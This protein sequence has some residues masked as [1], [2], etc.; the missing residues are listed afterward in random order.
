MLNG[1]LNVYKERGYTSFDVVA[2][3][4]GITKQNKIGHTGTLDP[5]AEGVLPVCLGCAT[6]ISGMLDDKDKTYRAVMLLGKDTDTQDISGTL[7]KKGD[8][9]GVTELMVRECVSTF[10]GEIDQIPPMYSALK[11]NG[12]KLVDLARKGQTVERK[13]RHI[14]VFDINIEEIDL[15]RVTMSVRCSR[16]T[17]IRTLCHDIGEK[18]GCYGTLESLIRTAD[19]GFEIKNALKLAEIQNL[20]DKGLL[21]EYILPVE[22][23]FPDYQRMRTTAGADRLLYNGNPL[24]K[25]QVK[26]ESGHR[27]STKVRMADSS[28]KFCGIYEYDACRRKYNPIKM[29]LS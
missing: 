11:V 15:P 4:R 13:P 8:T 7:L 16:G 25:Y 9:A 20:K 19:A 5:D 18:L 23:M 27:I 2:V 22:D 3:L 21:G 26:A 28:G 10:V 6:K 14:T 12:Q 17:Y 29:F 1:I 24:L